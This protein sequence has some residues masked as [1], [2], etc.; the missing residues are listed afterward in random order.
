MTTKS[1]ILHIGASKCGS[2]ALQ[3]ELSA[4]P[5]I[6]RTDKSQINYAVF[7]IK[8]SRI[9]DKER[10]RSSIGIHGY[11][12]SPNAEG[13]ISADLEKIKEYISGYPTDLLFSSE[14]W[15]LQTSQW[16]KILKKLDLNVH[17]VVYVRPLVPVLNSAWWQWG[18]W[19]D[20]AFDDWVKNRLNGDLWGERVKKWAQLEHVS[21]LTVRPVPADIVTDFY[22]EVLQAPKP[23]VVTRPNPSLPGPVLRLFQRNRSLRPSAHASRMDFALSDVISMEDAPIWVLNKNLIEKIL[24]RT[25]KDN[26]LLMSFM[27]ESASRYVRD[28]P[29]WWSASAYEDKIAETPYEQ[30]ISPKK[31]EEMCVKMAH[32]IYEL[33]LKQLRKK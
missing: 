21:S 20:Q 10:I 8:N 13:L 4:S 1:I 6:H 26:E 17:V 24:T 30:P 7:D 27:N 11:K 18:A 5:T 9:I 16:D 31:L 29:R 19:S 3:T 22:E 28:D 23:N 14:G 32:A 15:L 25:R 33:K 12:S 2:S